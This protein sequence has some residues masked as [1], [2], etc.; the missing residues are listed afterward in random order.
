MPIGKK[1]G[2]LSYAPRVCV[3]ACIF[4]REY[5][6]VYVCVSVH[7]LYAYV[8]E[9]VCVSVCMYAC[10][11]VY[12]CVY[13]CVYECVCVCIPMFVCVCMR[14]CACI[15]PP[16]PHFVLSRMCHYVNFFKWSSAVLNSVFSFL[17]TLCQTKAKVNSWCGKRWIH[18][19]AKGK[20]EI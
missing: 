16:P 9:F 13:V 10:I 15:S 8:D 3:W 17:L 1:S 7:A 12:A 19:F 4:V 18:A 6:C 11:R 20:S 5:V 14:V 2:N